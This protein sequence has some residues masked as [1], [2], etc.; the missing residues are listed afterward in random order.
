M[1]FVDEAIIK[2]QAGKGGNGCLSFR[3]EK[4]IPKGGPD[5]GDGG[6]HGLKR[7]SVREVAEKVEG[8]VPAMLKRELV[9][10]LVVARLDE[11]RGDDRGDVLGVDAVAGLHHQH[12]LLEGR[13]GDVEVHVLAHSG[14]KV[15]ELPGV[16]LAGEPRGAAVR[17][18]VLGGWTRVRIGLAERRGRV[19]AWCVCSAASERAS[20]R[21]RERAGLLSFVSPRLFLLP[22][23]GRHLGVC[24]VRA[25]AGV[26]V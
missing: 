13:V 10:E 6:G 26:G 21:E 23:V 14:W 19:G 12:L 9:L 1:K 17:G 24:S 18:S 7:K 22:R 5:G 2:V 15:Y 8:G 4:Y 25:L 11:H 3:R 16:R 20:E